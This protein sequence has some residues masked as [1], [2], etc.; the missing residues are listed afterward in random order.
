LGGEA[1]L[2]RLGMAPGLARALLA[3]TAYGATAGSNSDDPLKGAA[4]GAVT[5]LAGSLG[6]NALGKVAGSVVS[7]VTNP[8]ASYVAR[9]VPG[10]LTLGQAVSQS[11]TVGRAVKGIEDRLSGIPVVGDAVNTRRLEGL[12]KMNAKAFDRAL[13]PIGGKAGG[14][15]GPD[16]VNDAQQ[17]VSAAFQKALG[18]K[19]ASVDNGFLSAA[20]TAKNK[21]AA[22]PPS[23]SN[24]VEALVDSAIKDYVDPVTLSVRGEDVQPLLQELEGI[25][26]SYYS[27]G[28][29]A[30]K[31]IGDAVDEMIDAVEGMFQRQSPDTMP[32]YKAAKRAFKRVSTLENAV[33]AAKNTDGVF[34]PAQL[35]TADK[36]NTI[37]F[38][39]R[40]MAAAGKTEFDELH[41]NTQ[42]VLPN[43]VPDSG[44]AGRAALLLAP[45]MIAGSGAGVGYAAGNPEG[46]AATGLTLA[47][48]L[49]LAYTRA[50]QKALVGSIT[51]RGAKAQAVGKALGKAG[52]LTGAAG[53]SQ[54]AL[55][56]PRD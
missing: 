47:G 50:G 11:G 34:T 54:A 33:L 45:G 7:G 25:K 10:A 29:P 46:G 55:S 1:A 41:R 43:K 3:D 53:A 6:G 31:R 42:A 27:Q 26:S 9:E 35:G 52:R 40:H 19:V 4:I 12:Q 23:V 30:K 2:A 37:K 16:A 8:T 18:G 36:D 38:G 22:L 20:T 32:E 17:Q 21:I 51:G 5:G 15:F 48:L 13:E 49:A 14:K 28:H 56:G 39:N 44:T 24:D